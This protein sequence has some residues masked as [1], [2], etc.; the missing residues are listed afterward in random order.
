[1]P[2]RSK[3]QILVVDDEASV[4]ESLAMLLASAGYEVWLL[5]KTA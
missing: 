4:R 3:L 2:N 1:M 5:Q